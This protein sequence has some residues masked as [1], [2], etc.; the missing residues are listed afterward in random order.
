MP[1]LTSNMQISTGSIKKAIAQRQQ[2]RPEKYFYSFLLCVNVYFCRGDAQ[3][4]MERKRLGQQ[5]LNQ[6]SFNKKLSELKKK[7]K[8]TTSEANSA[9]DGEWNCYFLLLFF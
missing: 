2:Q 1:L 5:K 3:A 7:I 9:E 4:K 6:S 8:Q